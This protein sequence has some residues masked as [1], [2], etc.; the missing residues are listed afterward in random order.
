MKTQITTTGQPEMKHFDLLALH[1]SSNKISMTSQEIADLVGSRHDSV[2]RTIERL[3]N[4]GVIVQPPLVDERGTDS[5]GRQRITQAY[6]FS[7]E[8]GKRDSIIVVAQLYP[9]LT[10]RLVDRWRELES[11]EALPRS[12]QQQSA[13][14]PDFVALARTVTEATASAMMKTILETTGIQATIH[15]NATVSAPP[16]TGP[17][18]I[19]QRDDEKPV[20]DGEYV[21]IHKVSWATGLTDSA[22]RRLVDFSALPNGYVNGVRGLCVHYAIFMTAVRALIDESTPPTGKRKRWQHPEFGGFVLRKDPKEIFGEGGHG[23]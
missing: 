3:A 11:G 5:I 1:E 9:E 17:V 22:C 15:V 10:A 14:N 4:Q 18:I 13:I 7:D 6:V 12:Y 23:E 19:H 21:P 20:D 2:K 16:A 8:R